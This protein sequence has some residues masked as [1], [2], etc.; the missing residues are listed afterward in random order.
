MSKATDDLSKL[1]KAQTDEDELE[2]DEGDGEGK[3]KEEKME[4][5]AE[6]ESLIKANPD[7]V[8]ACLNEM[9]LLKAQV[10]EADLSHA[11]AV[12]V[13][14]T[15]TFKAMVNTIGTVVE[16]VNDLNKAVS[17]VN[18]KGPD[19]SLIKAIGAAVV[20]VS[21]R[22]EKIETQPQLRKGVQFSNENIFP[23]GNRF[24]PKDAKNSLIKAMQQAPANERDGYRML[25]TKLE[26]AG[27]N[28][29]RLAKAD[30]DAITSVVEA[31]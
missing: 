25:I 27:G 18:V 12:L 3:N 22:L 15:D 20:D 31:K 4:K 5:A 28:F 8:K 30:F 1:M 19:V 13:E 23:A 16:A 2:T 10:D 21:E 24:S 17:N 11:D 6:I 29:G 14:G 7:L 26:S 9:G